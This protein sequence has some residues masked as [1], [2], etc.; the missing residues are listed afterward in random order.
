MLDGGQAQALYDLV[1]RNRAFFVDWI[2]FVSKTTDVSDVEALI[3]RCLERFAAGEGL[4]FTL[5]DGS[6]MVAHVLAREIDR[7]AKW[8]EIGYMI[9]EAYT[10]R[11]IIKESCTMLIRHLFDEQ[12]MDKI[13]ICCSDDN[14]RSKAL[15]ARLGFVLEGTIRNHFVVNGAVRS[16]LHYG[17]LKSEWD[18]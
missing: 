4:F 11:G 2:P 16:M 9:D 7:E 17:L 8:A 3:R 6:T 13:V 18:V 10:R 14:E 5:W 15:A 12:R 1:E